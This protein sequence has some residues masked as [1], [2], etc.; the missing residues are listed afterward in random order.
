MISIASL[1][2]AKSLSAATEALRGFLVGIASVECGEDS[3][4]EIGGIALA[5]AAS[6]SIGGS[7]NWGVEVSSVASP[8]GFRSLP[9]FG[10]SMCKF[11]NG[12][13]RVL[14]AP[15]HSGELY[16]PVLDAFAPGMLNK[17][18]Q[19]RVG[20]REAGCS[21]RGWHKDFIPEKP[22]KLLATGFF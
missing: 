10:L 19:P 6:F 22:M 13:M 11:S 8:C 4:G 20:D 2:T 18:I 1:P 14:A 15:L 16:D 12:Q 21:Q 7:G 9:P 5:E 3:A 17:T